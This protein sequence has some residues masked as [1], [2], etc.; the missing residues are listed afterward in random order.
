V[1]ADCRLTT[2][3]IVQL[4]FTLPSDVEVC[5]SHIHLRLGEDRP[6]SRQARWGRARRRWVPAAGSCR[7]SPF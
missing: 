7:C 2:S 6:I 1:D 3:F 5:N 4:R